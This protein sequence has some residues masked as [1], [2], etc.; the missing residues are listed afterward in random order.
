MVTDPE[1]LIATKLNALPKYVASR[2]T[3]PLTWEGAELLRGDVAAAVHELK[4]RPGRQLQVHG[5]GELVRFLIAEGLLDEL[6]LLTFPVTAPGGRRLFDDTTPPAAWRVSASTVTPSG[7][8]AA[9]Y[10]P[11]GPLRVSDAGVEDGREVEV[12]VG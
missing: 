12:P 6:R 3:P 11:A 9:S 2:G 4:A 10:E 5:S 7:V 1:H 8:V